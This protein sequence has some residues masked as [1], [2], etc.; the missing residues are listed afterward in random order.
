M[1]SVTTKF[2]IK[3]PHWYRKYTNYNLSIYT[4]TT[5]SLVNS[6]IYVANIFDP[7]LGPSANHNIRT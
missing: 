5:N 7:K 2:C 1:L 3:H 6:F 4:V